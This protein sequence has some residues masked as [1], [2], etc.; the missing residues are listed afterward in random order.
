[1]VRT[2]HLA[3]RG[4]TVNQENAT[5][6][7]KIDAELACCRRALMDPLS[8]LK[9]LA[10]GSDETAPRL[11]ILSTY[12]TTQTDASRTLVGLYLQRT[13]AGDTTTRMLY[14]SDFFYCLV[15]DK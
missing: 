11:I 9:D 8:A 12:H 3:R 7:Y 10:D 6:I 2:L 1:L 4:T 13:E 15:R 5:I 14:A